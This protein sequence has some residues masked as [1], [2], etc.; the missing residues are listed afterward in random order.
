M[1][2]IV[3]CLLLSGIIF[4]FHQTSLSASVLSYSEFAS[5]STL[6][7]FEDLPNQDL[8]I[9][10]D[11]YLNLGVDFN[12]S[13]RSYR[14]SSNAPGVDVFSGVRSASPDDDI[15]PYGYR[16]SPTIS[17]NVPVYSVGMYLTDGID[18]NWLFNF[19]AYN[20]LNAL[21]EE[22]TINSIGRLVQG[23]SP[24]FIGLGSNEQISYIKLRIYDPINNNVPTSSTNSFEIDDLIFSGS[25]PI[26]EPTT[27]LLFGLGLLGLAGVSRKKQ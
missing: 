9:L 21:I 17:F 8:V 25:S 15:D 22:I 6:I 12:S 1:K 16:Y 26:P 2:K 11:Q 23:V 7:T 24:Y 19:S 4:Q 10:D 27:I 18:T 13:M 5:S 3:C 20:S 14:L